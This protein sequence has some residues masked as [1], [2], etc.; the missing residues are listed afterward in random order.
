MNKLFDHQVKFLEESPSKKMLVWETGTGKTRTSIEWAKR[1][2]K[3]VL[4][5]CPKALKK[6]WEREIKKWNDTD[7][8]FFIKTKEEFRRDYAKLKKY[9]VIIIDEFHY[10]SGMKSQMSKALEKYVNTHSITYMIGLSATPFM[11]NPW[12]VYRLSN[13]LGYHINWKAF[14]DE[15]FYE[16]RMGRRFVPV[17]KK[18]KEAD[19]AKLVHRMGNVVSLCDCADVPESVHDMETF[20]L[21]KEQ[22]K[23]I[24]GVVDILPI[25]RYTKHHQICGGSLKGN[26][27]E[28]AQRFKCDKLDRLLE[29]V[30]ANKKVIV[31]SRYNE[32]GSMIAEFIKDNKIKVY[33][34]NGQVKDRDAIIQEF[35]SLDEAVLV[36]QAACSEGWEAPT[37]D[38]MVF[39]SYDYS[40]KNYIQMLGRIQRINNLHKCKYISLVVSGT[41]DEEVYKSI[42][43]KEDFHVELYKHD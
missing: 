11:S 9:N 16:I 36:V 35:N 8:E 1:K 3:E 29:I 40:L 38:T 10:F 5:I 19:V 6:N 41:I 20:E 28:E 18:H 15:F 32:E 26:E 4:V 37:C 21:T 27:Y 14:R 43:R 31:V 39:Y 34:V 17:M 2:G 30:Q 33:E 25:V 7:S 23:A 24:E 13:L 22:K 42:Q 12:S